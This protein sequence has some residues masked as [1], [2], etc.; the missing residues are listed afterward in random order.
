MS[1]E[2][3]RIA[4]VAIAIAICVLGAY[5]GGYLY[6][7]CNGRRVPGAIG[8]NGIKYYV[9]APKYFVDDTGND[10][11]KTIIFF[12]PLYY[13]DHAFWHNRHW[14]DTHGR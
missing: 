7:T 11:V 14:I 13:L 12:F 6:L 8:S 5:I 10:Q 2:H 4:K 3:H 1:D 9:W